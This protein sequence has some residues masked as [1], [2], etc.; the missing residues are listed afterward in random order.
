MGSLTRDLRQG[1]GGTFPTT[2]PLSLCP[3]TCVQRAVHKP[4]AATLNPAIPAPRGTRGVSGLRPLLA[5]GRLQTPCL[6][7]PKG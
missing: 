7:Q 4:A 1:S 2:D 6:G 3:H 5:G